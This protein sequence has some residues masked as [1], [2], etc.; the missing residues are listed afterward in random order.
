[1]QVVDFVEHVLL[2]AADVVDEV[3]DML[4]VIEGLV[5]EPIVPIGSAEFELY[6]HGQMADSTSTISSR[7]ACLAEVYQPSA[8]REP[9]R[10]PLA[11]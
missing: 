3:P 1:M 8:I 9:K 4:L 2:G 7:F 6:F 10:E 11:R 5:E